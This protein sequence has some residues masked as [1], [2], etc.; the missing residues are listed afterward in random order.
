MAKQTQLEAEMQGDAKE[1]ADVAVLVDHVEKG[2]ILE[3]HSSK[4]AG[5]QA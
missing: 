3:R 4:I 5:R 1:S 2:K